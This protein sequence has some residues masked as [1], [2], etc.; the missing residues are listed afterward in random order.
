MRNF[1]FLENWKFRVNLIDFVE[2]GGLRLDTMASDGTLN[3]LNT[4]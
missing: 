1:E 2:P 3:H 4:M